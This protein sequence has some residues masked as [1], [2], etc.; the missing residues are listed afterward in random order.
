MADE[1]EEVKEYF[2]F[3]HDLGL[4]TGKLMQTSKKIEYLILLLSQ[5]LS[6]RDLSILRDL[7]IPLAQLKSILD[8]AKD[9]DSTLSVPNLEA[10]LHQLLPPEAITLDNSLNRVQLTLLAAMVKSKHVFE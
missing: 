6:P 10:A 8:L 1:G 3:M 4:T 7:T 5:V 9:F 2:G